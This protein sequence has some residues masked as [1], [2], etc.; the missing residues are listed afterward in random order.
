MM[1]SEITFRI[2]VSKL[3]FLNKPTYDGAF[4]EKREYFGGHDRNSK[5]K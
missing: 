4:L 1:R 3:E 5:K 2:H